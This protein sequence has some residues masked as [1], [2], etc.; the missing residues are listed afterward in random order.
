[1]IFEFSISRFPA[2]STRHKI[3]DLKIS[4]FFRIPAYR[5]SIALPSL[6]AY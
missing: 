5:S 1:M 4:N 6:F 3:F 2:S